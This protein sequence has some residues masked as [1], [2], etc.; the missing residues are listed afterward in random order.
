MFEIWATIGGLF[1]R[2][3]K[4]NIFYDFHHLIWFDHIINEITTES[5]NQITNI[6]E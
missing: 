2:R 1:N 5:R 6:G 3:I 4:S